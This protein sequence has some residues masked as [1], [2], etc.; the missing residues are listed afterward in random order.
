MRTDY[1]A[2]AGCR[3]G[4]AASCRPGV[5]LLDRLADLRAALRGI[6]VRLGFHRFGGVGEALVLDGVAEPAGVVPRMQVVQPG[7]VVDA[8][9][10]LQEELEIVRSEIEAS[11][12]PPEVEALVVT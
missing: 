5:A 7:L 3:G 2:A 11:L 12:G 8:V 10:H 6:C 1:H 4:A 9:R